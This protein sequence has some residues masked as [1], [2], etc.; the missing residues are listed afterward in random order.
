[1]TKSLERS[2]FGVYLN[3]VPT[4]VSPRCT[5]GKLS[6]RAAPANG[7]TRGLSFGRLRDGNNRTNRHAKHR[8]G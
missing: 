8:A 4:F 1:M 2:R 7:S 6:Q 3:D 5:T